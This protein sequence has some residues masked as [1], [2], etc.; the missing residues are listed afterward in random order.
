M[1]ISLPVHR[2]HLFGYFCLFTSPSG[3]PPPRQRALTADINWLFVCLDSMAHSWCHIISSVCVRWAFSELFIG[4][5]IL[6]V[7][8][9]CVI[10]P[11]VAFL[12]TVL[13]MPFLL[14][15]YHQLDSHS[16]TDT[17][18]MLVIPLHFLRLSVSNRWTSVFSFCLQ[19]S[20][21]S[22]LFISVTICLTHNT[23]CL[24]NVCPHT[25]K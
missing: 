17:Q 6:L 13:W 14:P 7:V 18:G 11:S 25:C 3:L 22:F 1:K 5:M 10:V 8:C 12:H 20:F 16:H 15:E 24:Q 21:S 4:Q 9:T 23:H 19:I 2:P